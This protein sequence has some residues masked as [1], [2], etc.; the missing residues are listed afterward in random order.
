MLIL[1]LIKHR[2][3]DRATLQDGHHV[4]INRYMGASER[5][6]KAIADKPGG[7]QFD[8]IKKGP[9]KI[10]E[11]LFAMSTCFNFFY[12]V[13]SNLK[14]GLKWERKRPKIATLNH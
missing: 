2:H 12:L 1:R 5:V 10:P 14:K 7:W 9:K 8:S 3:A 6:N 4:H 13:T 11:S